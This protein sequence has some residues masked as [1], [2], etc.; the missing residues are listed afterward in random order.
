M[1]IVRLRFEAQQC[2]LRALRSD[3]PAEKDRLTIAGY[4][5]ARRADEEAGRATFASEPSATKAE[6]VA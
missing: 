1:D 2:F 6:P 5:F 3:D 4:A